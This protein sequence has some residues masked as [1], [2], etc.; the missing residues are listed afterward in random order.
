MA[1]LGY[2][3][4]RAHGSG[5][6]S[7]DPVLVATPVLCVV[8]GAVLA[9]RVLPLVAKVAELSARSRRGIVQ[10]LAA[11]QI[12]RGNATSGAFLVVLAATSTTFAVVFLGTWQASQ[13][14]QAAV[15]V[16]TDLAVEAPGG[17][18]T[19]SAIAKATGG[20]VAPVVHRTVTIGSKASGADFI[21]F[22]TTRADEV[23]GGRS[24]RATRGR[25]PPPT[26]RPPRPSRRFR[27]SPMGRPPRTSR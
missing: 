22:D 4:L 24:A 12:A 25:R 2:L 23:V 17:I 6:G 26:S 13:E 1:V 10:P 9:L 16:G 21:A 27:S 7:I 14:D 5:A 11:W 20:N 18:D 3:Q 19:G 15:A 8:A